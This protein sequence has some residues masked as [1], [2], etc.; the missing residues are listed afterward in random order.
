MS[1]FVINPYSFASDNITAFSFLQGTSSTA[2]AS[3]YTFTSVNFGTADSNRRIVV[4]VALRSGG[5]ISI[6]SAT[7]GGVSATIL[8]QNNAV[9]DLVGYI[10]ASVPT[11]TDGTVEI[12]LSTGAARIAIATYRVVS[13]S[14]L[15]LAD[16]DGNSTSASTS[17]T[18]SI[19]AQNGI[20]LAAATANSGSVVLSFSGIATTDSNVGLEGFSNFAFASERTT[21]TATQTVTANRSSSTNT[22]AIGVCLT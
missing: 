21:A 8:A 6:S 4:G 18:L 13:N 5:G 1:A 15:T 12:V 10:T 14:P 20:V 2:N 11:G 7:I 19:D 9:G 17:T 3:T 16:S 22:V